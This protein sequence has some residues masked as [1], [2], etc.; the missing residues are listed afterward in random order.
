MLGSLADDGPF[1]AVSVV[2][3]TSEDG[4][5]LGD[6]ALRLTDGTASRADD[7]TPMR[8]KFGPMFAAELSAGPDGRRRS[9]IAFGRHEEAMHLAIQGIACATPGSPIDRKTAACLVDRLDLLGADPVMRAYFV[10]AEKQRKFCSASDLRA[11][12]ASRRAPR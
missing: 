5:E 8:T 12:G 2:R 11:A 4:R 6:T 10:A 3:R 1:V 7:P 9:C